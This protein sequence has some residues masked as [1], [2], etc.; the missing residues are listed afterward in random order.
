MKIEDEIKQPKFQSEYHKLGVNLA[1]T[2]NWFDRQ[3]TQKLKE[4]K[5]TSQQFNVLRI[6]R[7]QYPNPAT[8][9]LITERML[10]KMSNASR[11]VDKLLTKGLV[12]RK[13]CPEDRRQVDIIITEKGQELLKKID[14]HT[15][16]WEAP[17]MTLSKQEATL[18]N[19][20]L[21]RMRGN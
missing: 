20:F 11:L 1:F 10:D 19:D 15:K 5:L 2:A 16:D 4:F 14:E 3:I 13:T 21:D 12:D 8:I 17:L 6:L 7:G 9:N 18:M